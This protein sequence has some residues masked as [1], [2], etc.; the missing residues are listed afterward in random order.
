MIRAKV[1]CGRAEGHNGAHQTKES[2]DRGARTS[3]EKPGWE[4]RNREAV[5]RRRATLE[6]RD[7]ARKA[8]RAT[9]ATR[10]KQYHAAAIKKRY[11]ISGAD[12]WA[13][14]EFQ[15]SLCAIC[16][17]ARGVT[18]RLAVDHDHHKGCAHDHKKGCANC[19]RG[20]LC[21][22]CNILLGRAQDDPEFFRRAIKYLESPPW[23]EFRNRSAP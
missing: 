20:L 9:A 22:Y 23:H 5:K 11:G 16:R 10:K 7:V 12:Y 8:S 18:K 14:Y 21:S 3:M 1:Q 19:I 2:L 17:K 4:Q 13:L 6:G 15:Q